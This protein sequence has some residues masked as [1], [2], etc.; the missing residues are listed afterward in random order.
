MKTFEEYCRTRDLQEG[1]VGDKLKQ[2]AN[3][4]GNLFKRKPADTDNYV[5]QWVNQGQQAFKTAASE[6]NKIMPEL[7]KIFDTV[8]EAEFRDWFLR[9]PYANDNDELNKIWTLAKQAL[10]FAKQI[11][12]D[13]PIPKLEIVTRAAEARL[14]MLNRPKP[15]SQPAATEFPKP[16]L[17]GEQPRKTRYADVKPSGDKKLDMG[18]IKA[19]IMQASRNETPEF[20]INTLVN[21]AG[22]KPATAK[23]YDYHRS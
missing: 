21:D 1:W 18:N 19:F 2:G 6:L 20:I 3:W 22:L 15:Q 17:W 14:Q 12:F 4:F 7:A 9:S 11:G 8:K 10:N 5:P 13:K 23:A 16:D